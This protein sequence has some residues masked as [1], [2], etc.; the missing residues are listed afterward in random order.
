MRVFFSIVAIYD[1]ECETLD[2]NIA[3][4]RASV[5][6]GK[7]FYIEQPKGLREPRDPCVCYLR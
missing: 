5:L 2:F 6:E 1:I 3:F 7:E 4:L